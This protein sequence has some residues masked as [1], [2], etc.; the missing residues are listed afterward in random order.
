MNLDDTCSTTPH[1][2]CSSRN[3][4]CATIVPARSAQRVCVDRAATASRQFAWRRYSYT[5]AD[6]YRCRNR[7]L[8]QPVWRR[9]GAPLRHPRKRG[10]CC[11]RYR[12]RACV[13][14]SIVACRITGRALAREAQSAGAGEIALATGLVA[15]PSPSE[16]STSARMPPAAQ[17]GRGKCLPVPACGGHQPGHAVGTSRAKCGATV[18]RN[19]ACD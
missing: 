4:G 8:A 14:L 6:E 5:S 15:I 10:S 18:F 19:R 1:G 3:G 7:C 17:H 16:R 13:V 12:H 2:A 11:L 9:K